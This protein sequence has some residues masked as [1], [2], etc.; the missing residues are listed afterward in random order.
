MPQIGPALSYLRGR[1]CLFVLLRPSLLVE[2][3]DGVANGRRVGNILRPTGCQL[4]RDEVR[5]RN[6]KRRKATGWIDNPL[7]PP[8]PCGFKIYAGD[9]RQN[10]DAA[11]VVPETKKTASVRKI[12]WAN[13][14]EG[15]VEA[16]QRSIGR[17][18]VS[19]VS[20]YEEMMSLVARGCAWKMTA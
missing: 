4:R 19:R 16:G 8:L 12:L 11:R 6:E 1:V 17:L 18:S 20:L 7:N 13:A 9:I 2:R 14:F 10:I 3:F 15:Y 5:C